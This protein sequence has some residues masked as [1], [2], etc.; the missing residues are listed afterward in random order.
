MARSPE[1]SL[2]MARIWSQLRSVRSSRSCPR[3][4][5]VRTS[6]PNTNVSRKIGFFMASILMEALVATAAVT[7]SLDYF[8]LAPTGFAI[9][10]R[11]DVIALLA[12]VAAAIITSQLAGRARRETRSAIQRHKESER[13]YAIARAFMLM[14]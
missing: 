9:A 6:T 14:P 5:T 12:F 8:F 13:L 10:S 3:P 2:I 1:A 7:F 11:N 4:M